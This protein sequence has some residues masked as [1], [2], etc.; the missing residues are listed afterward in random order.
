MRRSFT[1]SGR[2]APRRH[3]LAEGR[4]LWATT[5]KGFAKP[6]TADGQPVPEFPRWRWW[7]SWRWTGP[8][9]GCGR[10]TRRPPAP[11]RGARHDPG[12]LEQM[13]ERSGQSSPK[14]HANF[15]RRGMSRSQTACKNL[16]ISCRG[17]N[18]FSVVLSLHLSLEARRVEITPENAECL[19]RRQRDSDIISLVVFDQI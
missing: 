16:R 14:R 15:R 5:V 8:A 10:R 12:T 13:A 4:T 6:S 9:A 18:N 17:V 1:P 3:G 19:S 7:I 2:P 11:S